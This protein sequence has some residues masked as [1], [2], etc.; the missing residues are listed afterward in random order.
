MQLMHEYV[1]KSISTTL[2]SNEA[3]LSIGSELIQFIKPL[4]SGAF[5]FIV[6]K[7]DSFSS[8]LHS[9]SSTCLACA[10]SGVVSDSSTS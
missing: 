7:D 10:S 1:Q 2:P 9:S 3:R 6:N 8:A 4:N 5:F